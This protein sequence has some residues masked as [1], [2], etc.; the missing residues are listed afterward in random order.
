MVL[1]C[2]ADHHEAVC[3]ALDQLGESQEAE[4]RNR[5][6]MGGWDRQRKAEVH[7]PGFITSDVYIL[8]YLLVCLRK[9]SLL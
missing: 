2:P 9:G 1:C 4:R 3:R 6:G 7:F 8:F 5:E